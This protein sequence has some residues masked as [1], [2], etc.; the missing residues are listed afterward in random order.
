MKTEGLAGE[1]AINTK[2]TMKLPKSCKEGQHLYKLKLP[3]IRQA[4]A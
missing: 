3:S 2:N 4:A 1:R